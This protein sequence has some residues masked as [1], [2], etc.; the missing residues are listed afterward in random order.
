MRCV[1]ALFVTL[2]H[3][4]IMEQHHNLV[5]CEKLQIFFL[6]HKKLPQFKQLVKNGFITL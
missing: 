2:S 5:L 3:L 1:V 6:Q 4:M